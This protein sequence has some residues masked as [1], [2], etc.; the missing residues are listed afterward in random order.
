M[1][2]D[3]DKLFLQVAGAPVIAHT[4]RRFDGLGFDEVLLVVREGMQAAFQTL[5][6]ELRPRCPWRLVAGGRERQDSVWNGLAALAPATA[7]VAIQDGAR[8]CT[9]V[10]LIQRCLEAAGRTGA[11]VGAQRTIDTMKESDDGL[12]I[13]RHLDRA[14]LWSVQTPQCFQVDLIRRA[15]V[16][17]RCRGLSL[18]DDT[19][20]CALIGQAVELVECRQPNP[21]VTSPLDLPWVES[22][23]RG[24]T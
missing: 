7:V 6:A 23:L 4:W 22:L 10:D 9:P 16:E 15:L 8:P 11:S 14:K 19:A 2:P 20:A 12:Q 3:T 24:S 17:A 5:A 1:G 13:S 21:K 18:T